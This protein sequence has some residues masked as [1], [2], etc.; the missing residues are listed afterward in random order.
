MTSYFSIQIPNL[1]DNY[2]AA[3]YWIS[4][5]VVA[6]ISIIGL[7]FFSKLFMVVSDY[8]DRLGDNLFRRAAGLVKR[9][10]AKKEGVK[11]KMS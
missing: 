11:S 4:F 8:L 9:K 2:T 10:R 7:L 5:A 3:T 6:G 1:M